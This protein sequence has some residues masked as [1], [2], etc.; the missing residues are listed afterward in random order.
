MTNRT[1]DPTKIDAMLR[2]A[3]ARR[4]LFA[5]PEEPDD[6]TDQAPAVPEEPR[7]GPLP[8]GAAAPIPPAPPSGDDILRAAIA[9]H[10][11]EYVPPSLRPYVEGVAATSTTFT[12]PG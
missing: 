10:R 4:S 8:G 6:G 3:K 12:V 7:P 9:A 1:T 11:G 5:V 2:Q